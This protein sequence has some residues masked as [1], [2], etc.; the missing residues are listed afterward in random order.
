MNPGLHRIFPEYLIIRLHLDFLHTVQRHHI[1]IPDGFVVLRRIAGSYDDPALR[2]RMISKVLHWRNCSMAG[3]S[4]SDTQLISSIK[5]SPRL[6]PSFSFFHKW[7][8]QSR[9]WCIP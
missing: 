5:E 3:A 9:S 4:V 7:T 8:P 6:N 1:E 2:N